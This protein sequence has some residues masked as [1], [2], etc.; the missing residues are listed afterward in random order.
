MEEKIELIEKEG[1]EHFIILPFTREFSKLSSKDFIDKY[2]HQLIGIKGLIVG[3]DH[4]FGKDR[5]GNFE[6][7]KIC[8]EK[9]N[10]KIKKI[11]AFRIHNE[12][13]SSTMIRNALLNGQIE[14]ANS[15]L[16][17]KFTLPGQVTNGRKV[18]RNLG[19][20]T[21]NIQP[22]SKYKLIPKDGVYAVKV[23]V[24]KKMFLGMLN[25]GT[26]PTFDDGEINRSIEVHIID[27]SGNLYHQNIKLHFYKRIR[28]ELRFESIEELVNQLAV[29]KSNVMNYFNRL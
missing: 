29:D 16:S 17:R 23:E 6:D 2:L 8:A 5:Q 15:Y 28:D 3:Y 22:D 20:P 7:L 12:N 18:G 19:F 14:K 13:I 1:I 10:F 21:A 26:R 25:I 4:K 24:E 11:D 9:Y 27:F